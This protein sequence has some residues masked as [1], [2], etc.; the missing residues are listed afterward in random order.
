M[1]K[2][3]NAARVTLTDARRDFADHTI[4]NFWI[5]GHYAIVSYRTKESEPKRLWGGYNTG[6]KAERDFNSFEGCILYLMSLEA[7]SSHSAENVA[8]FIAKG[9]LGTEKL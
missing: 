3:R 6:I 7:H 5:I 9:L 4:E 1:A 8:E 2:F